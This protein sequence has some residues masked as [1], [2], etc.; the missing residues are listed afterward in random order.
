MPG[1]WGGGADG[2]QQAQLP[3]Q[4]GPG[5]EVG[6][7]QDCQAWNDY[8]EQLLPP[9]HNQ[10]VTRFAVVRQRRYFSDFRNPPKGQKFNSL[11]E[12]VEKEIISESDKEKIIENL[13][14]K[15]HDYFSFFVCRNPVENLLSIYDMKSEQHA[16]QED[17][18][19]EEGPFL[20]WSEILTLWSEESWRLSVILLTFYLS[21]PV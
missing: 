8:V 6:D 15:N 19:N 20:T 10:R 4:R 14:D 18:G 2:G 21:L 17:V 13:N 5:A 3:L 16:H 9:D 7:V 11:E 12:Q 1:Q